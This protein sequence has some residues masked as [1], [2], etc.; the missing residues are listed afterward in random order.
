MSKLLKKLYIKNFRAHRKLTLK[1]GPRVNSIIGENAAG[2]STIIRAIRYVTRNKPSGDSVISWDAKQTKVSLTFGKNKI[3][4]TRSKRINTYRLNKD[5]VFK[6]FGNKVPDEIQKVLNLS[7]INFQ[8]QHEAPFWFCKTAGEVSRELNSIVNLD[9]ID[10]TLSNILSSISKSK[11][12]V[13]VINERLKEAREK[14]K[15]LFYIKDMNAQLLNIESLEKAKTENIL[16]ST[17]LQE[18]LESAKLYADRADVWRQQVSRANL[19]LDIALKRLNMSQMQRSLHKLLK[20]AK[21]LKKIVQHKPASFRAIAG[22]FK[23]LKLILARTKEFN[24]LIEQGNNKLSTIKPLK[25]RIVNRTK[26]MDEIMKERCPL[27][28]KKS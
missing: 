24:D 15:C 16:K 5:K 27:C 6:A 17:L 19:V 14:K 20:S 25:Q 11:V 21:K 26:R 9:S 3:T 18:L 2:K 10:K 13:S 8:G 1:F 23:N 22:L 7:D 28:N 12:T 4:R